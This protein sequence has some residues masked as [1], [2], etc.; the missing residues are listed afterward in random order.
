MEGGGAMFNNNGFEL[1][2]L[3]CSGPGDGFFSSAFQ[4]TLKG[5]QLYMS[6]V[7]EGWYHRY[8]IWRT[9]LEHL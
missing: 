3:F 8:I 4:S 7:P 5:N 1:I 9:P 2:C 6:E